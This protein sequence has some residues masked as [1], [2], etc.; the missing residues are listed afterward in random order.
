M[1]KQWKGFLSG[2]V[3][4]LLIIGFAVPAFAAYQKQATLNYAGI[5]ITVDGKTVVPKDANG[6]TVEPFM[7]D[8]TTYLPLRA[9]GSALGMDVGWEQA[10]KTATLRTKA[11]AVT[12][13]APDTSGATIGQQNALKKA[14]SYLS[15]SAFSRSG[16]IKQLEYEKFSTA[17]ATYAADNCGAN[18]NE[19]AAKKA[20][21]YLTY[22]S[23]SR[24]G[25]IQQ[26]EYEGFT[27][28]QAI[29]GADAVGY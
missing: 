26:L 24:D 25:L 5:S 27:H 1:E 8:G 18:W 17:D 22:S 23:F 6:N 4:A 14:Q 3:S 2:F 20:K 21:S 16:L 13:A 7:I 28:D 29:Y 19:Q 12:P 10:T 15:F 11:A 9:I